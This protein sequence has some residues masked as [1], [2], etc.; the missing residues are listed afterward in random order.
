VGDRVVID[1]PEGRHAVAVRRIVVGEQVELVDGSGVRL[2]GDVVAVAGRD[3]L[4]VQVV[5][6]DDEPVPSPRVVVVQAL[7]KGERGDL[8]V[9]LLTEVGVDAVVPWSASR[10]VVQW[11]GEKAVRGAERWRATAREAGKQSRRARHPDVLPLASTADV[12]AMLSRAEVALVLHEAAAES[13]GPVGSGVLGPL[14]GLRGDVV[15][16]VGP[17]GG[18]APEEVVAFEAVGTHVH[19]VAAGPTV[20]RTSTAGAVVA[21]LVLASSGR[22]SS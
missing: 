18:I 10:T 17:E 1:G 7:P 9:E 8:A 13:L 6:R 15:L 11:R 3:T 12:V 16:V 21:A 5:A 22:W 4:E 20:M 14:A 19:V 2:R